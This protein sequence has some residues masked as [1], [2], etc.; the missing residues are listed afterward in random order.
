MN[1]IDETD[2]LLDFESEIDTHPETRIRVTTRTPQVVERIR[3]VADRPRTD[4]PRTE[5]MFKEGAR[6]SWEDLRDYVTTEIE[7]RFGKFPRNHTETGIFK[8]FIK[9]FPDGRAER[10]A[11]YAFEMQNGRWRGAPIGIQRFCIASDPYFADKI[12]E[13]LNQNS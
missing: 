8:S 10:I 2:M 1:N 3:V 4:A 9:R 7:K 5:F 12:E 13:Y 6:W 11:R